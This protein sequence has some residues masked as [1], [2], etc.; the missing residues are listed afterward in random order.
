MNVKAYDERELANKALHKIINYCY[1]V[2]SSEESSVL[3]DVLLRNLFL[4]KYKN[5]I[6]FS[7]LLSKKKRNKNSILISSKQYRVRESR[8]NR[9]I[10]HWLVFITRISNG[11]YCWRGGILA[12]E[13]IVQ[14]TY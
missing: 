12:S 3:Y 11:R 10:F 8:D 14:C 6:L 4:Y 9:F 13:E 1:I 7:S 5:K 2:N